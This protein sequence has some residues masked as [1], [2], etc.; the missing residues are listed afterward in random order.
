MKK[1]RAFVSLGAGL[2]VALVF[3]L[4]G[5]A[6]KTPAPVVDRLYRELVRIIGSDDIREKMRTQYFVPAGTAPASLRE[7]MVSEKARWDK[8]IRTA[9]VQ[10]EG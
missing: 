9:G 10:P 5:C 3:L 4:G 6:S 8:V 7:T 2:S 1:N